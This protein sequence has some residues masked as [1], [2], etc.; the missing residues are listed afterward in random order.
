M[1]LQKKNSFQWKPFSIK[2]KK[3]MTWWCDASP[4]KDW[5]GIIAD[6]SVRSGKT[7]SMA[8]AFVNWAMANYDECD[9]AL[10]G[11]TVGSLRRNVINTLKQQLISLGYG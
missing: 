9:F 11:K 6:G 8:P 7:V 3:I 4:Y 2:Q 1:K 10:C 5:N